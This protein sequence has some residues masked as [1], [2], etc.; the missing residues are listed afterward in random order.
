MGRSRIRATPSIKYVPW[1]KPRYAVRKRAD[2]PEL[3]MWSSAFSA[4]M[5]PPVPKTRNVASDGFSS[6]RMP[7]SRKAFAIYEVSSLISAL[8]S[9]LTPSASAAI[10][11]T[12]LVMLFDPGIETS[13]SMGVVM[14]WISRVCMALVHRE[15]ILAAV[16]SSNA[17]DAHVAYQSVFAGRGGRIGAHFS[18]ACR[19]GNI[20]PRCPGFSL[21]F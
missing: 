21:P 17:V 13:A 3:P 1:P 15:G 11:S 8:S 19:A 6:T 20:D 2:V 5:R 10:N 14:G 16:S 9:W 12:R 7:K 18:R 4:G